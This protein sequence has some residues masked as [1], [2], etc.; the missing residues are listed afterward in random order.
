MDITNNGVNTNIENQPPPYYKPP[1]SYGFSNPMAFRPSIQTTG[2]PTGTTF[3]QSPNNSNVVYLQPQVIGTAT[4]L[5]PPPTTAHINDY[6]AWSI[7]NILCC[8]L[9]FGMIGALL[10]SQVQQRK[11][12]GD[13]AGAQSLSTATAAWNAFTTLAGIGIIVGVIVYLN[14]YGAL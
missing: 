6:M 4:V 14:S 9:L 5:G 13:V 10:S 2:M 11:M 8:G 12:A 7:F 3:V 1:P